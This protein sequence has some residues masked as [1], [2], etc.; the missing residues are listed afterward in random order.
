MREG[1]SMN[2]VTGKVKVLGSF[3]IDDT[4]ANVLVVLTVIAIVIIGILVVYILKNKGKLQGG[5]M[6]GDVCKNLEQYSKTLL[7]ADEIQSTKDDTLYKIALTNVLCE[8]NYSKM[9]TIYKSDHINY[10]DYIIVPDE[11]GKLHKL[12][13]ITALRATYALTK[14]YFMTDRTLLIDKKLY[15]DVIPLYP[16]LITYDDNICLLCEHDEDNNFHSSKEIKDYV[17]KI[18]NYNNMIA[19]NISNHNLKTVVN[20]IAFKKSKDKQYKL[21]VYDSMQKVYRFIFT[22]MTKLLQFLMFS[23]YILTKIDENGKIDYTI[24]LSRE[25]ITDLYIKSYMQNDEDF[26]DVNKIY[27]DLREDNVEPY[28]DGYQTIIPGSDIINNTF[29]ELLEKELLAFHEK[30]KHF[31]P[32]SIDFRDMPEMDHVTHV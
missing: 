15:A 12:S 21:H 9:F 14:S 23:G 19:Y 3:Y 29:P 6:L 16:N 7:H 20:R 13:L 28:N 18:L 27:E 26:K 31:I 1:N 10:E 5:Y 30:V 4:V 32:K 11:Y 22:H 17:L 2:P 25:F 8:D 24:L